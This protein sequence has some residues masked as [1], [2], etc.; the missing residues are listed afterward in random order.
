MGGT[1][2]TMFERFTDRARRVV[3]LAQEE[4]RTLNHNYIGTEHILLG[5]LREG[6]GVA[7]RV[8]QRIGV[9]SEAVRDKVTSI[10]GLGAEAAPTGHIPFTPRSKKVL[11]L[12]LREA[13]QLGHN[14]IGTEHILL[15]LVRE[16][17]GVAAQ[18]L[19]NLGLDMSS[20]RQAVID[21]LAGMGANIRMPSTGMVRT[22]ETP[23][24]AKAAAEARRLAGGRAV[25]SQHVLRGLMGQE[26]SMAAKA[27]ADL[28]V[29]PEALE[30][31]LAEL[32]PAGTSDETPEEAGARRI[33]MRV[34]D[35]VLTLEID[36]AELAASFEKALTGR[37]ARIISGADP[38]VQGV[39]FAALWSSVSRTVDDLSR[40]LGRVAG[41]KVGPLGGTGPAEYW[42]PLRP[43]LEEHDAYYWIVSQAGERHGYLELR[44]PGDR[45]GLRAWLR[46]WLTE[47]R[48][49]L[50]RPG[51][52]HEETGCAVL[53]LTVDLVE[54][55]FKVSGYGVGPAGPPDAD[56]IPLEQL[57][58][59]ALDDLSAA[60]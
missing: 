42:R 14:Y 26:D 53:W 27:L 32:D 45:D 17:Q 38:E 18:V 49:S 3:V 51:G 5:L 35:K 20:V 55:A 47:R 19:V 57:V 2:A 16:G 41:G 60:A 25:G 23:A 29:T 7:A 39:G 40:R 34:Q 22:P 30:A 11:E 8:L 28:G 36:D 50:A 33:R 15:G 21:E 37:K 43:E 44:G 1:L 24:A 52:H 4:A 9:S 48:A 59:A 13:L 31:K 58:D 56:P 46:E 6:D 12:S 10:I 54:G